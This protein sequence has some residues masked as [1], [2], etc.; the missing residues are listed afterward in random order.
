M[1]GH[2]SEE[3]EFRIG[4]FF[5]RQKPPHSLAASC[6]HAP[7]HGAGH[8][9]SRPCAIRPPRRPGTQTPLREGAGRSG[10]REYPWGRFGPAGDRTTAGV[11]VDREPPATSRT[12]SRCP[13]PDMTR[14][15]G[16]ANSAAHPAAANP[17]ARAGGG[18]GRSWLWRRH[19]AVL[20]HRAAHCARPPADPAE[21]ERCCGDRPAGAAMRDGDVRCA[22]TR[23]DGMHS[24]TTARG[25]YDD[26]GVQVCG[27]RRT[28]R[29]RSASLSLAIACADWRFRL[30]GRRR[31]DSSGSR[32]T[33]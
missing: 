15:K 12:G 2:R 16:H 20:V 23:D 28:V 24:V 3:G 1:R 25:G 11:V 21:P 13:A 4:A 14:R 8:A 19:P 10:A 9:N 29:A 31:P 17:A 26:P 5:A 27:R 22:R 6:R 7:P 18:R 33:G 32:R 30:K